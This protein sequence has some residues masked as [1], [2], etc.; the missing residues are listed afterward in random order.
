M[1]TATTK[2]RDLITSYSEDMQL[3]RTGVKKVWFG[4]LVAALAIAPWAGAALGGNYVPYLLNLTGI[5]VIVALGLNLLTGSA[6]LISLG[7][8]GFL[9]TG[10]Y[11]AGI[12]ATKL[13][14]PFW[15][16][17]TIAG[18]VSGA[19]G[20]VVGLPALRLRGL[21]LA[22][23]TLAFHFILMHVVSHWE[24]MTGG[25]NGLMVPRPAL[26]SFVFD[27]D[28]RFYYLTAT[29]A[30]LL[31]LGMA[32]LMRSRFGRALVALRD[33]DV[34]AEAVGVNLARYKTLAF[35]LSAAYAGVAGSLFAHYLGYIGPDHFTVLL[36]VEYLVMIIVG[37][38]GSILGGVLGAVFITLMPEAIRLFEDILRAWRP[39]LAFPD[40]RGL[41]VGLVLILF[42]AFEPEGLASRWRRIRE[43]WTTWPF[44]K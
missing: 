1:S 19:I 18:L 29:L 41:V 24:S 12:L 4:I 38:A 20:V 27:T 34:A 23:A 3:F 22:L 8:A 36:S 25:A 13:A 33:S 21:Y 5:A 39:D 37:G 42:I 9:A 28:I 44:S 16:T 6:G 17:V 7:H 2:Y 40:L 43:Y 35:G 14:F 26:G 32:N 31:G 10:A 11:T 30:L 15:M